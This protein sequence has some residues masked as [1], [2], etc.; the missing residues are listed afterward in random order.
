MILGAYG[1]SVTASVLIHLLAIIVVAQWGMVRGRY[2][3]DAPG[4][5]SV[6]LETESETVKKYRN[7][8]AKH[9]EVTQRSVKR[10]IQYSAV[11]ETYAVAVPPALHSEPRVPVDGDKLT[12]VTVNE[13]PSPATRSSESDNNDEMS[14]NPV[15]ESGS[16]EVRIWRPVLIGRIRAAIQEAVS[17]PSLARKRGLEGT[18]LAGFSIDEMGLPRDVRVLKSSGH[19]IL[20]REVQR[21]IRRASPYPPL[22]GMIE[23]PVS[24]R[25]NE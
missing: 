8:A 21:I 15:I 14:N 5:I 4:V 22:K 20:D 3:N 11:T 2:D 9:T 25:L 18:V 13:A 7:A 1:K 23:V 16:G 12:D 19:G 6:R 17:Y 10:D 24:F